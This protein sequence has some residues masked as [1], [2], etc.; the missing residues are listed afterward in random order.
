M[1]VEHDR[2]TSSKSKCNPCARSYGSRAQ[3]CVYDLQHRLFLESLL[4]STYID[5]SR[6]NRG[7]QQQQPAA[8][9]PR[10][11]RLGGLVARSSDQ[12]G[13]TLQ[14]CVVRTVSFVFLGYFYLKI[15]VT[16]NSTKQTVPQTFGLT[17]IPSYTAVPCF[18]GDSLL[19]PFDRFNKKTESSHCRSAEMPASTSLQQSVFTAP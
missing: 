18:G 13:K 5:H 3:I 16:K 14:L 8:E 1:C 12:E 2:C 7:P 10:G 19:R 11:M 4:P 15:H 9:R 6:H 17:N